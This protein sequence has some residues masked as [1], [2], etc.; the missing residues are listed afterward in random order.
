MNAMKRLPRLNDYIDHWSEKR[1]DQAAMIQYEDGKTVSYNQ[2]R[3]YIDYFALRLLDMGIKKGDR[4]A[5][6]LVLV[7]EHVMLMYACF[8]IGAMIAPLDL[9]L[10]KEEIVRDINKITPKAFF[11]LGNTPVTDFRE[12]GKAV[13]AS[14]PGV[15][16]LVQFTPDPKPGEIIEGAISITDMMKKWRLVRLKL[17]DLL[18]KRL[19][20]AYAQIDPRTP[21][22]IIYTTG[23]TGE[24]KPAM[25]CHENIIVQNQILERGIGL[26]DSPDGPGYVTLINLPPSHVGCVTETM[27]TTFFKGGTAILLRIFD[28]EAT[29]AAIEKH[30]VTLLGQIPTQFRMLWQH[31]NYESYDLSSLKYVAYAGSAGDTPFLKRLA[32]M[33]PAFGTGIG[34]TENAGFATFTPPDIS[35]EEMAG[36]VGRAFPDLAEVTIRQPMTEDGYAGEE[37]PTGETGEICYHPP[38]VFLGYFNQPGE[39]A[40]AISKEGILYTGDLGYFKEMGSYN[41]LYLSGRRKFVIKQKGYNVFPNEVEEHIAKLDGVDMVDVIGVKHAVFDEGI[42]AFVRLQKG[43]DLT[44][45]RIMD[46]CREIAAY[47]RPQHI[48]VW[49]HGQEFPLTRSAKIDKLKLVDMAEDIIGRLRSEGKWDV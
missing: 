41:A 47:K 13:K 3:S 46:H 30:K 22:L 39:T 31:P 49:P 48:E 2:F 28:V 35:V 37:V 40:K 24:P 26:P 11:F 14:C 9:R 18:L 32:A 6:Q 42:F 7:P 8:K 12:I 16:H 44:A 20:K 4:V 10:K 38:I 36:Q 1:P 29:L 15:D 17:A 27:M 45:G 21:A 33:A 34:M 25:L 19:K 43:S 5:T 23:T